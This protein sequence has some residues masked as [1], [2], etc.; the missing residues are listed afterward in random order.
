MK[1]FI[2]SIL[3]LVLASAPLSARILLPEQP[4]SAPVFEPVD[5]K[6]Q[7]VRV[8]SDGDGFLA[9]FPGAGAVRF[10]LAGKPLDVPSIF[11]PFNTIFFSGDV[12]WTGTEYVA[13]WH[14]YDQ[15][16]R[17]V[18]I[19]REGKVGAPIDLPVQSGG[20]ETIVR[21]A[22]NGGRLAV[23]WQNVPSYF[24]P[25][26]GAPAQDLALKIAIVG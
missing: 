3:V 24:V 7:F 22:W 9:V 2:P 6:Y 18:T 11:L 13:G 14:S 26:G 17:L 21:L 19:S 15:T 25:G 8:A 16:I 12:I 5:V 1:A 20:S 10:D 4:V 23:A